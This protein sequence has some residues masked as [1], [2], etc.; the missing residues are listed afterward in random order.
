MA[1]TE[2]GREIDAKELEK[3][4]VDKDEKGLEEAISRVGSGGEIETHDDGREIKADLVDVQL[5]GPNHYLL[6]FT[7]EINDLP[8]GLETMAKLNKEIGKYRIILFI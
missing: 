5:N 7:G 3:F 2:K 1:I 8:D 4:L 6:T